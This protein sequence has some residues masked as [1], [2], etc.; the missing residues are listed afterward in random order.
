MST[1]VIETIINNINFAKAY[2]LLS[3]STKDGQ[4]HNLL[5]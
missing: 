3:D 4:N 5:E 2:S 1:I